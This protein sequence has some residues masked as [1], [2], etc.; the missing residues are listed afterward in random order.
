[1]MFPMAVA[2]LKYGNI[3]QNR[4][5][6]RIVNNADD[7]RGSQAYLTAFQIG[8]VGCIVLALSGLIWSTLAALLAL[9]IWVLF[10]IIIL[11]WLYLFCMDKLVVVP[12]YLL[13][14]PHQ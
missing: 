9:S 8:A 11:P 1:M 3:S 14:G 5:T 6:K 4:E 12:Y 7:V 2:V 10:S 13:K